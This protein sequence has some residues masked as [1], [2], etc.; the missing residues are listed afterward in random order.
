MGT[1]IE[2][3]G[4][5]PRTGVLKFLSESNAFALSSDIETF[6]V[7]LLEA[8]AVGLPV[9]STNCGGPEEFI[10]DKCGLIS[11]VGDVASYQEALAHIVTNYENYSP[12]EIQN[13]CSDHFSSYAINS[14]L[15]KVYEQAII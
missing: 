14:K 2:L 11:P 9:L 7:V 1:Q 6:G 15:I 10:N 3:L 4:A 5:L 12:I 8:M 13:Y